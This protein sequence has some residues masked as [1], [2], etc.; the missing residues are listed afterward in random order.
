MKM[1]VRASDR[2]VPESDLKFSVAV[3]AKS[4]GRYMFQIFTISGEPK[5]LRSALKFYSSP[6]EAERAGYETLNALMK[7][8]V[9]LTFTGARSRLR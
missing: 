4:G 9:P 7:H 5:T 6:E 8:Q 2:R 3:R 1:R